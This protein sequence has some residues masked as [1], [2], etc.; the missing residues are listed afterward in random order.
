MECKHSR[1]TKYRMQIQKSWSTIASLDPFS[2]RPSCWVWCNS[3]S[4][5]KVPWNNITERN[6]HKKL[7][8]KEKE[9]RKSRILYGSICWAGCNPSSERM[10]LERNKS[11]RGNI[12][13]N[14]E[15]YK[16]KSANTKPFF[17]QEITSEKKL[18]REQIVSE[19]LLGTK[20][21]VFWILILK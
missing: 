16:T 21:A 5:R 15:K 14:K 1:N 20:T 2:P 10:S 13:E 6:F 9:E 11:F 18:F 3:S 17:L 4:Q 19:T 7:I 8:N 12:I